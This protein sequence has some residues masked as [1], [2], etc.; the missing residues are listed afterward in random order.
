MK[1]IK[2]ETENSFYE[3]GLMS[4]IKKIIS[5]IEYGC[6]VF[7]VDLKEHPRDINIIFK[8][9]MVIV[10]VFQSEISTSSGVGNNPIITINIPF[11]SNKLSYDTLTKK[12]NEI[13]KISSFNHHDLINGNALKILPLKNEVQLTN[14][15][16]RVVELAEQGNNITDISKKLG[17]SEKT[18]LNHRRSAL[19]KLGGKNKLD[20]YNYVLQMRNYSNN[21]AIFI[22]I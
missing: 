19:I 7:S 17:R 2:I 22:C 12:I 16:S 11:N 20:F 8:E 6:F 18:I 5:G 3:L 1:N 21:R 9:L 10:N 13:I 14:S 15:E 4:I